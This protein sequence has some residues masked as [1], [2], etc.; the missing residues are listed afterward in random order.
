MIDLNRSVAGIENSLEHE[1]YE[2]ATDY[3]LKYR[4]AILTGDISTKDES[5]MKKSTETLIRALTEQF[6]SSMT[7]NKQTQVYRYCHLLDSL[8]EGRSILQPLVQ[9]LMTPLVEQ[10]KKDNQ[11]LQSQRSAHHVGVVVGNLLG[12]LYQKAVELVDSVEDSFQN[13]FVNEQFAYCYLLRCVFI[14]CDTQASQLFSTYA[15]LRD[16][17]VLF[18]DSK[19]RLQ[20]YI[21]NEQG[22]EDAAL[23]AL[24][25]VLNEISLILQHAES[26][27]RYLTGKMNDAVLAASQR[28]PPDSEMLTHYPSTANV[29]SE[30][31]TALR[32]AEQ[33]KGLPQGGQQPSW[34]ALQSLCQSYTALEE[35]YTLY[36]VNR[37]I[38]HVR[39]DEETRSST[40]PE[41][42][43]YLF[44][45]VINRAISQG[46][47][48]NIA[49]VVSIV[50][51]C[52]DQYLHAYLLSVIR[53][54]RS[55]NTSQIASTLTKEQ[56]ATV[57]TMNDLSTCIEYIRKLTTRVTQALLAVFP[58]IPNTIKKNLDEM[59]RES[60]R[61]MN[62]SFQLLIRR[63]KETV[64][65]PLSQKL[66]KNITSMNYCTENE[67]KTEQQAEELTQ[68]ELHL[69]Q[70][71]LS[72]FVRSVF[73]IF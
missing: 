33:K 58:Q 15:S 55:L 29:P 49:M 50:K 23:D 72:P 53:G 34:K 47:I 69:I 68:S 8:G 1:E 70:F 26:F 51:G 73:I 3:I 14:H 60:L 52:I 45:I 13:C 5:I 25:P 40:V 17:S 2:K 46:N 48:R 21:S 7:K 44:E 57:F 22:V 42:V 67:L 65:T 30:V 12:G 56:I 36:A 61:L 11:L 4:R 16:L 41:E 18:E 6:Q 38:F 27:S 35:S 32:S 43:F 24:N 71:T 37:S 63:L 28:V 59:E 31:V 9:Y 39:L 20:A 19:T 54:R 62:E 64:I 10:T 66:E